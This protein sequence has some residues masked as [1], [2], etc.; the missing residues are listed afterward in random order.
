[1]KIGRGRSEW[2]TQV[3]NLLVDPLH[4]GQHS[5]PQELEYIGKTCERLLQHLDGVVMNLKKRDEDWQHILKVH[6]EVGLQIAS[7]LHY[8]TA[9]KYIMDKPMSLVYI[10]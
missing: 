8:K 5:P 1:M 7:Y 4:I 6:I 3:K 9:I 2:I 10:L